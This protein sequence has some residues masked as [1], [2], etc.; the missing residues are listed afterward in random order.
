VDIAALVLNE[1]LAAELEQAELRRHQRFLELAPRLRHD[2]FRVQPFLAPAADIAARALLDDE[3]DFRD[4]L[5]G[6]LPLADKRVD[7]GYGL[8]VVARKGLL[9]K[10]A[11]ARVLRVLQVREDQAVVAVHRVK[12]LRTPQCYSGIKRVRAR[13]IRGRDRMVVDRHGMVARN[14][15]HVGAFGRDNLAHAAN[16]DRAV[17][18]ADALHLEHQLVLREGGIL[19]LEPVQA[20]RRADFLDIEKLE[21]VLE[22]IMPFA[23]VRAYEGAYGLRAPGVDIAE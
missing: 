12:R 9:L 19:G 15:L 3:V 20:L 7:L 11:D 13:A 10:R 16:P 8:P 21:E 4:F 23:H 1:Y 18:H 6:E 22:M 17:Q 5:R 14:E 2:P